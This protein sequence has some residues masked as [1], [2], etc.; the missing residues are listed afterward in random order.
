MALGRLPPKSRT[1]AGLWAVVGVDDASWEAPEG[2]DVVPL[3]PDCLLRR[4]LPHEARA[5][6]AIC[7]EAGVEDADVIRAFDRIVRAA[8]TALEDAGGSIDH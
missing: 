8:R 7:L 4:A 1:Q 5:A 6:W 2:I 3:E